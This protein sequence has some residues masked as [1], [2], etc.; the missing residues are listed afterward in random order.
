MGEQ[1]SVETARLFAAD[2]YQDYLHLHGLGVEMAESL[3]ELLQHTDSQ[4]SPAN[5]RSTL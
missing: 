4:V 3:A 1:V 5:D 2:R